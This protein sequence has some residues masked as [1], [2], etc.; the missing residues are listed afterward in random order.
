MTKNY[1][2]ICF[3]FLRIVY[4]CN[5]SRRINQV[6]DYVYLW[7]GSSYYR[8]FFCR[9]TLYYTI[10]KYFLSTFFQTFLISSIHT[11]AS[12]HG[13]FTWSWVL[14]LPGFGFYIFI[15]LNKYI[16]FLALVIWTKKILKKSKK[17]VKLGCFRLYNILGS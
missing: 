7:G 4:Y 6:S 5:I 8:Q 3:V 2:N 13:D 17:I 12:N 10:E 16:T 14:W 15:L 11:K 1:D 9:L